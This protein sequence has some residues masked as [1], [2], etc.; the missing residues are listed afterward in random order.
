M[1]QHLTAA[2]SRGR[3]LMI[4]ETDRRLQLVMMKIKMAVN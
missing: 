1:Q 2:L 3:L 4:M